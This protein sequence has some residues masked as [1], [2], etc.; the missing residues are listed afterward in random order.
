MKQLRA[1]MAAWM[2]CC[3]ALTI[4]IPVS[5]NGSGSVFGAKGEETVN[6]GDTF[7]FLLYADLD[8]S[9][10]YYEFDI[11]MEWD[12][13]VFE[14][15]DWSGQWFEGADNPYYRYTEVTARVKQGT[16]QGT[17]PIEA[18]VLSFTD[19]SA[20]LAYDIQ[21][22]ECL[23]TVV[24]YHIADID[25][26]TAGPLISGYEEGA[27][28]S[29]MITVTRTGSGVLENLN[30]AISGE[31]ASDFILTQPLLSALDDNAPATSF[32]V[33]AKDHLAPGTHTAMVTVSADRMTDVSF[34][35]TQVVYKRLEINV[36]PQDATVNEGDD[37]S[38]EVTAEGDG[39]TYQWQV[40]AGEGYADLNGATDAVLHLDAVTGSMSG[41]QY[42]VKLSGDGEQ[43]TIS[44]PSVLTVRTAPEAP[45]LL[46]VAS[47]D[48]QAVLTWS[49]AYG[50][51]GYKVFM[52]LASGNYADAEERD[53]DGAEHTYTWTGLL[54]GTTYY[55]TVAGENDVGVG[56]ASNERSAAPLL[57]DSSDETTDDSTSV[58]SKSP[59]K[60]TAPEVSGTEALVNGKRESIGST[61]NSLREGRPV[62]TFRFDPVKTAEKLA[63]EAVGTVVVIPAAGSE[64]AVGE[65]DGQMVKLMEM[66]RAV[67][68]IHTD[69]AIYKLP[70]AVLNIDALSRQ[71]GES[72]DLANIE[73]QIE[74]AEP[75]SGMVQIAENAATEGRFSLVIQPIEFAIRVAYGGR[76]IEVAS[77]D[78][79]VERTVALPDGIDPTKMTTGVVIDPDGTVRHVPTKI[80]ETDGRYYATINS[81]TNSAYTVVW[82]P[83]SFA[84]SVHHWAQEAIDDMG[85]RMV[86][87]G[88]DAERYA[89]DSEITRAE[90]AA[91]I[92]RGLGL[93]QEPGAGLFPDVPAAA[94]YNGSV[95]AASRNGLISGFED[96]T[97]RPD[98]HVTREQAMT[99]IA[100]AMQL[101]GLTD[102]L[103]ASSEEA[104]LSIFYDHAAISKWAAGGIAA[105]VQA[106]I[107]SGRDG[108]KLSPLSYMTRAEV[109]VIVRKL[110]RQSDLI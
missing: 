64:I 56:V 12:G 17:Y 103:S 7:T 1:I 57:P 30:A 59:A 104:A 86:V 39:L 37:T 25:D 89:P 60:E 47:G 19:G 36:Q 8:T 62:S 67:L 24:G 72:V 69:R 83:I 102:K 35:V 43:S 77:F 32:T 76:S 81:L 82:H 110:L 9:L 20:N 18:T 52:S 99:I 78:A 93:K 108:G 85:S 70:A 100:K 98:E 80:V 42:R 21:R 49:P 91:I 90:F 14:F 28:E 79:Y 71:F 38:F 46:T 29:K 88:I 31:Q 48:G 54:N 44:A 22:D 33:Q 10:N 63:T 92:V 5:A 45:D 51:T 106:G 6:P 107:V 61:T 101:T 84:D 16:A 74:V 34:T 23:I 96:G 105:S 68:E 66:N 87:D 65:M 27:P 97:F 50:A 55:F 11:D 95:N 40:D 13:D 109:A 94:G 4:A 41:Y 2:V 26:V 53:V 58:D 75:T 3:L 15:I 73:V